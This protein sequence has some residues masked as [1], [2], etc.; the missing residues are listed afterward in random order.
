[1]NPAHKAL[2]ERTRGAHERV[3]AVF[4]GYD[5]SDRAHYAAM[6]AAHAEVLL[7][8]EAALDRAGAES[9]TADW[10]ERRRGAA[11]QADLAELAGGPAGAPPAPGAPIG[12]GGTPP[13]DTGAG[14]GADQ[15]T[16]AG[17]LY[18]LEGSRLGGRFLARQLATGFPRR[19]LDAD[20][21]RG[22]WPKL[23]SKL[24]AVLYEPH[25]L[26]TAVDAA[27][28]VFEAFETA[29]RKWLAKV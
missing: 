2:R 15:A 20:Q 14:A 10:P 19:Y 5:L 24:D 18:V 21:A 17:A 29:G 25:A 7:P 3:D 16:I 8:L 13:L 4:A 27:L 12:T 9:V 1:M 26:S 22:N 6:L 11:L 28:D 23:L